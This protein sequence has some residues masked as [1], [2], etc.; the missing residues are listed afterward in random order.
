MSSWE[1]HLVSASDAVSLLRSGMRIFVHGAAATPTALLDALVARDD[2]TDITLYHLHTSG[3]A[4]FVDPR[5]RDRIRSVSLFAGPPVREA[6]ERG[7]A[8]FIPIFLSDIP[9]M[10][11]TGRIA[12]DA[13]LLHLSVPDAHGYCTLGTSVDAA[14]AAAHS[15]PL[16][17]AQ[18]NPAMPRTHGN[19]LIPFSRLRAAVRVTQ[20]LHEYDAIAPVPV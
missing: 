13:A 3:P 6:I 18:V 19:T 8:D 17:I 11:R 5:V 16:L 10:F 1:G 20:P 2:L 7:D 14:L 9:A 15:A 4:P 12:L